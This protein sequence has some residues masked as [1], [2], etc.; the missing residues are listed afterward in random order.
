MVHTY[1]HVP[2][3]LLKLITNFTGW[4]SIDPNNCSLDGT[5]QWWPLNGEKTSPQQNAQQQQQQQLQQQNTQ[6][7][8]Q[9]LKTQ[10]K[11]PTMGPK[12]L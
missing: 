11:C 12:H 7:L 9:S 1:Y 10:G 3:F 6:Q 5:L 4:A 2:N 8:Q